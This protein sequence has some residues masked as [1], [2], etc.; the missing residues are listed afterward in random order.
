M[1]K[2][3]GLLLIIPSIAGARSVTFPGIFI[4]FPYGKPLPHGT[5][6]NTVPL[7]YDISSSPTTTGRKVF[8]NDTTLTYYPNKNL[9]QGTPFSSLTA[10]QTYYQLDTNRAWI[11]NI[12]N[13]ALSG[14]I[15]W[16]VS[17]NLGF[18]NTLIVYAPMNNQ[19][20]SVNV[21]TFADHAALT[22][23]DDNSEAT[24]NVTYGIPGGGS[25]KFKAP[26]PNYFNLD[27][28]Y[29]RLFNKFSIGPVAFGSWDTTLANPWSKFAVGGI[30]G[31]DFGKFAVQFWASKS[32]NSNQWGG[33]VIATFMRIIVPFDNDKIVIRKALEI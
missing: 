18:S 26:M 33:G 22:Y 24:V 16:N 3:I 8:A 17:K 2:K 23:Y 9:L 7:Y 29:V 5:Y 21:W 30:I 4:G 32:T 20:L 10:E 12:Y 15:A 27:L 31:Y 11:G 19:G 28:T 14:G 6:L 25:T 13:P 1:F